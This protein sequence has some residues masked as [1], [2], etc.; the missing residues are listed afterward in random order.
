[1]NPSE[2]HLRVQLWG[3]G[4]IDA[5]SQER[6]VENTAVVIGRLN[7]NT[8]EIAYAKL[9]GDFEDYFREIGCELP[10]NWR[11]KMAISLGEAATKFI[12]VQEMDWGS[13]P[14]A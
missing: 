12:R 8:Y 10:R 3:S 6:C 4:V 7:E 9:L 1:M 11:A 14:R 5:P 13:A 2:V